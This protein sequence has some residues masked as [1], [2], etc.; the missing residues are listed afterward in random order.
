MATRPC[1]WL[2]I[3]TVEYEWFC[4]PWA[5]RRAFRPFAQAGKG[6]VLQSLGLRP[7]SQGRAPSLPQGVK[8]HSAR[9]RGVQHRGPHFCGRRR[10]RHAG[11]GPRCRDTHHVRRRLPPR[12]G[13]GSPWVLCDGIVPTLAGCSP[14][15]AD[16]PEPRP[17]D[18][19]DSPGGLVVAS[20]RIR[21]KPSPQASRDDAR[22]SFLDHGGPQQE[23]HQSCGYAPCTGRSVGRHGP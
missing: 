3:A 21:P 10:S 19:A 13:P 9:S 20:P 5:K 11:S 17:L 8:F 14:P 12:P 23:L 1:P 4:T 18:L 2:R 16:S 7:L 6:C 15:L 22:G